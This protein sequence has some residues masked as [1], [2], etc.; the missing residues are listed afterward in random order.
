LGVKLEGPM[1]RDIDEAKAMNEDLGRMRRG[2]RALVAELNAIAVALRTKEG[3][4]DESHRL[5]E[6]AREIVGHRPPRDD[7]GPDKAALAAMGIRFS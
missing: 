7:P 6:M 5:D 4:D 1:P 3:A 2:A